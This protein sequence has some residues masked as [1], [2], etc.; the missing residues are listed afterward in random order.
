MQRTRAFRRHQAYRHM[1]R[2][3]KE[4]WNQHYGDLNC[5]CR[6][7]RKVMARFREQPQ[8]CSNRCCGNQRYHEGPTIQERRS[9]M[10]D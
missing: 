1:W 10:Q 9:T 6:H 2:R 8:M 3:L 7:D 4:D 5:P